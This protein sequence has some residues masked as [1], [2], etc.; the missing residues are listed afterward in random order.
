MTTCINHSPAGYLFNVDDNEFCVILSV[1]AQGS[2]EQM[3]LQPK[4]MPLTFARELEVGLP[5]GHAELKVPRE[6]AL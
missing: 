1:S 4:C 3:G 6:C 2:Y 5:H